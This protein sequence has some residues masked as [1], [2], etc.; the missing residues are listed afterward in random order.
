VP[1]IATTLIGAVVVAMIIYI[2]WQYWPAKRPPPHAEVYK[3]GFRSI[4]APN[5]DDH[6]IYVH[7]S[8]VDAE[9][10]RAISVGAVLSEQNIFPT[11]RIETGRPQ[12][13]MQAWLSESWDVHDANDARHQIEHLF[14]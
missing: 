2:I 14:T 1:D 7:N 10:R 11:N 12:E 6:L 4:K 8:N 5:G 3:A 9:L 13:D